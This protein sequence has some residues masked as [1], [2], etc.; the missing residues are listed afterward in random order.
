M[1]QPWIQADLAPDRVKKIKTCNQLLQSLNQ[2][3][4]GHGKGTTAILILRTYYRELLN[5]RLLKNSKS[6]NFKFSQSTLILWFFKII[7]QL[8]SRV[9]VLVI[10]NW[11]NLLSKCTAKYNTKLFLKKINF[12]FLRFSLWSLPS[13]ICVHLA[14]Y[15]LSNHFPIPQ[16]K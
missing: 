1:F 15:F 7:K 11:F 8:R 6:K 16:I 12:K 2:S 5:T 14:V 4:K 3:L 10:H 13:H 9:R